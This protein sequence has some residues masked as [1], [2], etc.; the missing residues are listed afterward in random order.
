MT[1]VFEINNDNIH[2]LVRDYLKKKEKL[3]EPLKK[4]K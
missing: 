4:K 1:A 3:P 2:R